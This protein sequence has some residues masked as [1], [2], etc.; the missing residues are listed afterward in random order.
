LPANLKS[1]FGCNRVAINPGA[2]GQ[3]A[4]TA[5]YHC[6]TNADSYNYTPINLVLTPQE[7]SSAFINGTYHLTDNVDVYLDTW[8]NKTSAAFQLAPAIIGTAGGLHISANSY[9]NPFKSDFSQTTLD[10]RLRATAA[11]PR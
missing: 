3:T 8:H 4:D 7:R 11:G 6:F 5:N 2:T 10:Y 9:Y 1:V